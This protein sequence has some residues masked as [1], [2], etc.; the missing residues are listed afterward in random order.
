ML[1]REILWIDAAI[2]PRTE[3]GSA[4]QATEEQRTVTSET[5]SLVFM[6]ELFLE[7]TRVN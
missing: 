6:K 4:A 3:S 1:P 5:T 7:A 2:A